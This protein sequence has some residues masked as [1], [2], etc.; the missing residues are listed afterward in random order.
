M[1]KIEVDEIT[2]Q[3]GTTL[4]VGG[5]ASKTVVADATTVTLGR[6]G[7][8]VALASGASQTGFGRTGT[9]NWQTTVKTGDFTAANGEGYFVNTT[10]GA[11]TVT[12]PSSPSAGD[13]VAV[14]DYANTADTNSITLARNSSN[15]EGDASDF[16][17][18][19]EGVAVTL[20]FAD[21]TKGWIVT[22]TGN[23]T[24]AFEE[25]FISATGG[26]IAT[27]GNCKIHTFTGPGTFTVSSIATCAT[28]N[29]VSHLIIGGGGGGGADRGGGGGAGGYREVKNPVTPFSASP[30]DGF[31]CAPNRVTV[32]ATGFP[33]AVGGG[34]AG[35]T[36]PAPSAPS[37]VNG[38]NSS[39]GGI[40]S[41]GGG[42]GKN[43]NTG[44]A[45][46]GGSGGGTSGSA[47]GGRGS[48]NTPPVSPPQGQNGGLGQ[49]GS[50]FATG[51]GG[52]GAGAAGADASAPSGNSPAGGAGVASEISGSSVT[53]AGGGGST[54]KSPTKSGAGGS[55]GGGAGSTSGTNAGTANTGGGGGASCNSSAGAGG[56]GIVVIRYKFQ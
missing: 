39:F 15:I 33:I 12:L 50:P 27:C 45:G 2:Q 1:S 9:V 19:K 40:T 52:G 3:S 17:I 47:P 32:T 38:V 31:S 16:V 29:I 4:T 26:T 21:S 24:D 36:Q 37:G 51:A 54:G 42:G 55:G 49:D 23:S 43:S 34:G 13:I 7:G 22:D 10:S 30:L 35:G 11:I 46:S 53:R 44:S 14:A 41:A 25:R 6:C 20:V 28:N 5:G 8:T 56:S 18:N 48:G